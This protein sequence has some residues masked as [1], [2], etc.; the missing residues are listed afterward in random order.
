MESCRPVNLFIH[1][2]SSLIRHQTGIPKGLENRWGRGVDNFGTQRAY[3]VEHFG[4][5]EGKGV[6]G[7]GGVGSKMLML[8]VV[9]YGYN[10][11]NHPFFLLFHALNSYLFLLF[12][13]FNSC[14]LYYFHAAVH[15]SVMGVVSRNFGFISLLIICIR[16]CPD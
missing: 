5:S 1:S 14:S 10:L 8:P 4:I 16:V 12:Q 15:N 2:C 6:V 13:A 3:G 9:E 11:W 7:C